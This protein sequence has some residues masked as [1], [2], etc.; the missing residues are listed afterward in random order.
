MDLGARLG[1]YFAVALVCEKKEQG[2]RIRK[3]PS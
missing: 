1:V 3:I 2:F